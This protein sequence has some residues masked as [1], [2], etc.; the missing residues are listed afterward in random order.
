MDKS[1]YVVGNEQDYHFKVLSSILEKLGKP[2]ASGLYHLS[3]GMVDLPSGKMKSREGTVVDADDLI[4]EMIAK[5]RHN[6]LELGKADQ[7]PETEKEELFRKVGMAALK[8]YLLRVDPK[9]RLLF[10]PNESIDL[11][12]HTGPF[13][14]Y[15]YAR[16][17][18]V[19]EKAGI[20][21]ESDAPGFLLNA[22]EKNLVILLNKF[23]TTMIE[24]AADYNPAVVANYLFDLAKTYKKFYQ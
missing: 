3:Y 24:S 18:S 23:E 8:Y 7:L 20:A 2:W 19:L 12:G 14:Q 16:I 6:T 21:T 4:D 1:V 10:D 15:T 11:Q 9:K 5:A 13:I 17:R 22:D